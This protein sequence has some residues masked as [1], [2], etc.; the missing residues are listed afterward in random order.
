MIVA[1]LASCKK[2]SPSP[3]NNGGNNPDPNPVPVA[4][5]LK[6]LTATTGGESIVYNLTY[7]SSKLLTSVK[8]SDNTDVTT[9]NYDAQ[10]N[11]TKVES[12]DP[13]EHSIY[14]FEYENGNPIRGTYKSYEIEDG[15]EVLGQDNIMH[16]ELS[17]G[18]VTKI[19][20]DMILQEVEVS[21]DLSYDNAG[22]LKKIEGL[23]GLDYTAEFTY[24][25]KKALF[26]KVF[27]FV[28][29]HIGYS[30]QYFAK[31]DLKSQ[32]FDFPGEEDDFA[33]VLTNT[34]DANGYVTKTVQGDTELTY[35]Y[36]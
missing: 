15:Q 24:G 35:E 14:E 6:R 21:F 17:G 34:Y 28:L 13:D 3:D 26:P 27:K 8:S 2:D 20:M 10:G 22:N 30:A 29:D 11:V 33:N 23:N 32:Q 18:K 16:Y 4:K 12:I 36:Q 5:T 31:N 9:Y 19:I 1:T 7:N 25:S